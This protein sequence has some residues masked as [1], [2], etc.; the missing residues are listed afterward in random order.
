MDTNPTPIPVPAKE[1]NPIPSLPDDL[2]LSI[3]A[4][5]SRLYYPTLSLVSKSFRSLVALPVLYQNRSVINRTESCLYVCLKLPPDTTPRWFTL[6]QKPNKTLINDIGK[7]KKQKK[8][9]ETGN[10]L[11]P[12]QISQSHQDHW[13][14][15]VSV[16]SSIYTI[17]KEVYLRSGVPARF[18][19][20]YRIGEEGYSSSVWIL[21]SSVSILD[22]T[23]HTWRDGPS[24][25]VRRNSLAANVVDGKIYVAGGCKY[26]K[27]DESSACM[28]VFDPK[29]QVWEPVLYPFADKC[30][31]NVY[32]S[33][34][35]DGEINMFGNDK[36]V[37][38]K[39]KEDRWEVNEAYYG[40][41]SRSCCFIGNILYGY[42]IKEGIKWYDFKIRK[43]HILKGY[44]RFPG[45][46]KSH[47]FDV[48]LV[49]CNG[50]MAVLW[51]ERP[52]PPI[53]NWYDEEELPPSQNRMLWCG[54]IKL[55]KF[56][57]EEIFGEVEWFD[58][59]LSVPDSYGIEHVI[60][61]TV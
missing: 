46:P 19:Y 8:S 22:C 26:G 7:K 52:P 56:N 34:V 38:Y 29:T 6:C 28:E 27:Y 10:I 2:L 24:M 4:R 30:I 14:S 53:R 58:P 50:K 41:A 48:R 40:L 54:V 12:I 17:G 21:D 45:L 15:V 57:S 18:K 37:V 23:S 60:S 31:G 13:K 3:F 20:H 9:S 59:V 16:G 43:W 42:S 5:L 33:G 51:D 25:S 55:K 11:I 39:P 47:G 32:T 1:P 49:D 36:H 35:V 61:A 44:V